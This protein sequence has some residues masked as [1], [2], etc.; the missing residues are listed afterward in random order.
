MDG[1]VNH[2]DLTQLSSRSVLQIPEFKQQ[3][4]YMGQDQPVID[5]PSLDWVF[6]DSEKTR[7]HLPT[8]LSKTYP[9]DDG[10]GYSRHRVPAASDTVIVPYQPGNPYPDFEEGVFYGTFL[11]DLDGSFAFTEDDRTEG[12]IIVDFANAEFINSDSTYIPLLVESSQPVYSAD[13]KIQVDTG[14]INVHRFDTA[15]V[16][17]LHYHSIG[18]VSFMISWSSSTI[19]TAKPFARMVFQKN[20]V[21]HQDILNATGFINGKPCNVEMTVI[22]SSSMK[23]LSET[24]EMY[25]YPIP[26]GNFIRIKM[27]GDISG[28]VELNIYH[29]SGRK[30]L[31][32][33]VIH[34]S[35]DAMKIDLS[36]IRN[37]TY[38]AEVRFGTKTYRKL[39]TKQ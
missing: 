3:W 8:R 35:I 25:I 1:V 31:T 33:E 13:I 29:T 14:N 7:F 5:T 2:Q 24:E 4:N 9:D 30:V 22:S 38:V 17:N 39:F 34:T 11:G 15:S 20:E 19:E 21:S 18:D 16:E 12:K 28:N 37:G 6:Y 36:G 27:P 23:Q 26:A 10:T 32:K